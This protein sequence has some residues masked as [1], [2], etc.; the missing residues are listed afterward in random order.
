MYLSSLCL[1]L[2]HQ[3][4]WQI[5][6]LNFHQCNCKS[7]FESLTSHFFS[8]FP[9]R[10]SV[11]RAQVF[12]LLR[13]V[14]VREAEAAG[15][16]TAQRV[17]LLLYAAATTLRGVSRAGVRSGWGN[18]VHGEY[19][20]VFRVLGC[21]QGEGTLFTLSTAGCL[22]CCCMLPLQHC[23]VSP[24]LGCGQ[25]EGTLFTVSTAGCPVCC[26][27][28]PL[29]H[30]RVLG[31]GVWSGWGNLVHSEYCRLSHVLGC[32]QDEGT[33]FKVNIFAAL[34]RDIL[35]FPAET[36]NTELLM[37]EFM[38][39]NVHNSIEVLCAH[40]KFDREICL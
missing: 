33:L 2:T 3:L 40:S 23:T 11:A 7:I 37:K 10:R 36:H 38:S 21:A 6:N 1:S 31:A 12:P 39:Q 14:D 4:N 25:G 19:Y 13:H 30:C 20:R 35:R 28:L 8:G 17:R 26:C 5:Q 24:V 16:R 29:Q 15:E 27:M 32:C 22:P 34:S 9:E 18:L